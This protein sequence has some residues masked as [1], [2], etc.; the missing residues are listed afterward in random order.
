MTKTTK[1]EYEYEYENHT[2]TTGT[3]ADHADTGGITLVVGGTGKTGRKVA[4]RLTAQGRLVRVGSRRG[5]PAFDWNDPATWRPALE[6]VDRV[7][8]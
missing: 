7:Y 6:D 8:V 3:I 4:E 2:Q 1:Y 5:E